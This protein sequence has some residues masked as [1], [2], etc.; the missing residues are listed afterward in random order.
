MYNFVVQFDSNGHEIFWPFSA[1]SKREALE[2]IFSTTDQQ[3]I[4]VY[5]EVSIS[6]APERIISPG[7]SERA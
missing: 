6:S 4:R 7:E 2:A 5:R 3:P 1:K